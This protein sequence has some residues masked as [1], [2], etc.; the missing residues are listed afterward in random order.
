MNSDKRN[1]IMN[2]QEIRN[3]IAKYM[4]VG[5]T[6]S[7]SFDCIRREKKSSNK[8]ESMVDKIAAMQER[9]G[10]YQYGFTGKEYGN[11]KWGNQ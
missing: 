2:T 10:T 7:E 5:F 9:S 3:R 11:R 8:K 4:E 6:M 1:K